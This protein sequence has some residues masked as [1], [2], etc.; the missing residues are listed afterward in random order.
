MGS[1]SVRSV[2][3]EWACRVTPDTL[4][5]LSDLSW[6]AAEEIG[7]SFTVFFIYPLR[8]PET[9]RKGYEACCR[10]VGIEPEP[11]TVGRMM[12][13]WE[14]VEEDRPSM[15]IDGMPDPKAEDGTPTPG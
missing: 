3:K 14:Q 13:M 4:V 6:G 5:R 8:D 7:S 12:R 2:E 10:H 15:Y 11:L 9:A 1:I